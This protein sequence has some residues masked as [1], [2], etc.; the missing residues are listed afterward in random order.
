MY[1]PV[2]VHAIISGSGGIKYRNYVNGKLNI[3]AN[4][5]LRLCMFTCILY[6]CVCVF[7]IR[8][9]Y[10]PLMLLAYLNYKA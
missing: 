2:I 6:L 9:R 8:I 4:S 1:L 10:I 5:C 7:I 3:V